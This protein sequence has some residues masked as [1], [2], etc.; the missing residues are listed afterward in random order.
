MLDRQ[1]DVLLIG[2]RGVDFWHFK[3]SELLLL[4]VLKWLWFE[5]CWLISDLPLESEVWHVKLVCLILLEL[6]R[7]CNFLDVYRHISEG[8][9]SHLFGFDFFSNLGVAGTCLVDELL[10][11]I[12]LF[13][14]RHVVA[15]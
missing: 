13:E 3:V 10:S 5:H 12:Q 9:F 15:A 11:L 6:D 2:Y 4:Q 8:F 1:L 14:H 7:S